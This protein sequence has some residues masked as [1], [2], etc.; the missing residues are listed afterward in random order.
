[1]EYAGSYIIA[2]SFI[3]KGVEGINMPIHSAQGLLAAIFL[4]IAFSVL[5]QA[6]IS[7]TASTANQ[8]HIGISLLNSGQAVYV[9]A[10]LVGRSVKLSLQL[11]NFL[12]NSYPFSNYL[13]STYPLNNYPLTIRLIL[14]S[15]FICLCR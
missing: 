14:R 7:L 11:S 5:L 6:S 8:N 2:E 9:Y 4:L 12:P 13:S 10:P 1:M 3:D 15:G